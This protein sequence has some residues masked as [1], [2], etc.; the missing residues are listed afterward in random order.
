MRLVMIGAP[1][2]G[3]G[4]QA[5][6][7]TRHFNL[8]HISTGEMLRAEEAKRSELGL[9]VESYLKRGQL[10]PDGLVVKLVGERLALNHLAQ[11]FILDGF[12]RTLNQALALDQA[13]TALGQ[14][15]DAALLIEVP[16]SAVLER[17][18]GRRADPETGRIY[19]LKYS[20]PPP[21]ILS[22]L[23]Q[24]DDDTA[25]LMQARLN[26]YHERIAPVVAHY[27]EGG[28]LVAVDGTSSPDAVFAQVLRLLNSR[29]S[30]G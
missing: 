27:R 1:A 9:V 19:H 12:P 21:E 13:L 5:H 25:E 11:G 29:R 4:T 15:I 17:I 10:V 26:T 6:K 23:E 14:A 20:P 16:D 3:K 22:R 7:L 30:P 8:D 24:R 18:T 28:L 2:S